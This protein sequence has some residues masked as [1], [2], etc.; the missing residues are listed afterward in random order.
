MHSLR[1]NTT[2]AVQ[3]CPRDGAGE[4]V[5][6]LIGIPYE[7][8]GRDPAT[9]LDCVGVMLT[10]YGLCGLYPIDPVWNR[11]A[12]DREWE[13]VTRPWIPLDVACVGDEVS[14]HMAV[15]LGRGRYLTALEGR[16]VVI[17]DKEELGPVL[18]GIRFNGKT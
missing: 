13:A 18:Y 4:V 9:G 17:V 16:G 8:L 14:N 2:G 3:R 5:A 10:A 11:E 7:R 15:Y 6:N 12:S 1:N